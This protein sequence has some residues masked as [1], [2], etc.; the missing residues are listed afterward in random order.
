MALIGSKKIKVQDDVP[1]ASMADIAFLLLIFFLVTTTFPRD[2]GLPIVLPEPTQ[3]LAVSETNLLHILIL[4]SGLVEVR[5]GQSTE[6]A[7]VAPGEIE[8]IWRQGAAGNP[9]LIAAVE[10]HPSAAYAFMIDV[11]DALQ[12]A[13][14]E[15]I[16]LKMLEN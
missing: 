15:R 3:E 6:V 9:E 14:A 16:S 11:V 8:S 7:R 13:G 4:S 12:S 5:R 10:T 2:K 1:T